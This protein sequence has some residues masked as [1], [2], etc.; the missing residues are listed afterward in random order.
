VVGASALGHGEALGR[1]AVGFRVCNRKEVV[2]HAMCTYEEAQQRRLLV[3]FA[4]A[5]EKL[6]V[7]ED[8]A[9]SRTNEGGAGE[10]GWLWRE[11]EKD[12]TEEVLVVQQGR[13]CR[14]GAS[15]VVVDDLG[16]GA[17]RPC[18]RP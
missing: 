3:I 14:R 11:P 4:E 8:V 5:S 2:S 16:H 10:R 17:A 6:R 13:R 7:G 9:P 15:I 12:L 1:D 18:G